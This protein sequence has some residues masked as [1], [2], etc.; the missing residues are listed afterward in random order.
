MIEDDVWIGANCTILDDVRLAKGCVIG[1][2]SVVSKSTE[3]FG[4]YGGVPARLI[5]LRGTGAL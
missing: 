1:A 3:P 2:G 4:I 5:R